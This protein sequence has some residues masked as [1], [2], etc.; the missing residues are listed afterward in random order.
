MEEK[1]R[2]LLDFARKEI[3]T[4]IEKNKEEKLKVEILLEE[5]VF[6]RRDEILKYRK[7][8]RIGTITEILREEFKD[9]DIISVVRCEGAVKEGVLTLA[10]SPVWGRHYPLVWCLTLQEK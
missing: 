3:K 4:A 10:R 7:K 2:E 9:Y 8:F 1:S 5:G 6:D